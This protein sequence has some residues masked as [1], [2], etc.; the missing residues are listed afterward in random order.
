MTEKQ[1]QIIKPPQQHCLTC[2]TSTLSKTL[3]LGHVIILIPVTASIHKLL[4]GSVSD[5]VP[6]P[7]EGGPA[8]SHFLGKVAKI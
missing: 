6:P 1:Q 4:A 5:I 7:R 2:D 8:S 3:L